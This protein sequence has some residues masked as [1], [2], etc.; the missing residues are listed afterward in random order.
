MSHPHSKVRLSQVAALDALVPGLPTSQVE[1]LLVPAVK[2]LVTD[3]S[4][5]V[6]EAA[7]AAL[8]HWLGATPQVAAAGAAA[9]GDAATR[10]AAAVAYADWGHR[11]AGML[12]PQLL[13]GVSDPQAE[14]AAQVLLLVEAVG[15]AW[16]QQKHQRS[17]VQPQPHQQQGQNVGA[18]NGTA[19]MEVDSSIPE[20]QQQEAARTAGVPN[21]NDQQAGNGSSCCTSD[22]EPSSTAVTAAQLPPPYHGLPASGCRA[23]VSSLLPAMLPGC[24]KELGEWTSRARVIAAR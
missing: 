12:L 8:A 7:F 20:Q 6:R 15:E 24:L 5:A 11:H 13:L 16:L 22:A 17:N 3:R 1:G 10:A 14:L 18:E 2:P 9:A 19:P 23:M 21:V 4:P